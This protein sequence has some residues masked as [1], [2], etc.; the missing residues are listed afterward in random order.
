MDKEQ[1]KN[2]PPQERLLALMRDE[3]SEP[4]LITGYEPIVNC[5]FEQVGIDS[6]A[7]M[8]ILQKCEDCSLLK[9]RETNNVEDDLYSKCKTVGD[10]WTFVQKHIKGED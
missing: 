10:L 2:L 8:Q 5:T 1:L 4:E 6:L 7:C 9:K 3:S